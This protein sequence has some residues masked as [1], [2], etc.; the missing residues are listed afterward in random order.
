M[1]KKEN[2]PKMPYGKTTGVLLLIGILGILG[3]TGGS[4][5]AAAIGR[6][7]SFPWLFL[8]VSVSSAFLGLTLYI[9][10]EGELAKTMQRLERQRRQG[11]AHPRRPGGPPLYTSVREA[12]ADTAR[13]LDRTLCGC[14]R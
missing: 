4:D 11:E 10:S 2:S 5:R 8:L 14:R 7:Q 1:H 3:V 12:Q 6:E 9:W 13:Y